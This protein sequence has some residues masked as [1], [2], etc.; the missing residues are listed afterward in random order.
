MVVVLSCLLFIAWW[1][2]RNERK[3]LLP[4]PRP[5]GRLTWDMPPSKILEMFDYLGVVPPPPALELA[6]TVEPVLAPAVAN[7]DLPP[8]YFKDGE[9]RTFDEYDGQPHVVEYLR[10]AVR[11]L[12]PQ[13]FAI[14]PQ[15]FLGMAGMGKTLLAKVLANEL[16]MRAVRLSLPTPHFIEA[17]PADMPDVAALDTLMRRV[18][19]NPGCVLFVDEIHDLSG[20]HSRKLYLVL[21]EGRYMF[22]GDLHPT[23]LPPT[24]LVAATTDWGAVH[25]ALKRRWVSHQLKPATEAQL[26][27]YIL[28]RGFPI[29]PAAAHHIV[30]RTKFSGAPWEGLQLFRVAVTGAKGRGSETVTADDVQRVFERMEIDQ[31]GLRWQDRRVLEVLFTQPKYR[32]VKGVSVFVAWA[33]SEQNVVTLAGIDK[34]EYREAVR[35][36]L[37]SR[38]LLEIRSSYGQA[39]TVRAK[40]WY[41]NL[42]PEGVPA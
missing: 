1:V 38:G 41:P 17:F 19:A 13:E 33:A 25:A 18:V 10:D 9:P 5:V 24:T 37:M 34:A 32:L 12:Q 31:Y 7:P 36:R 35:P 16:R 6:T 23:K 30:S 40:E 28:R 27:Q 4:P 14:E 22:H 26:Y 21:E 42:V 2:L 8:V 15:V 3:K 39:L 20:P 29:E 11:A